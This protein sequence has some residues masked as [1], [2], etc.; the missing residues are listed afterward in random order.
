LSKKN[1]EKRRAEEMRRRNGFQPSALSSSL[2]ERA[3]ANDIDNTNEGISN[4]SEAIYRFS[5]AKS[6]KSVLK[7]RPSRKVVNI[8]LVSIAI[9][10]L[11]LITGLTIIDKTAGSHQQPNTTDTLVHTLLIALPTSGKTLISTSAVSPTNELV[12]KNNEQESLVVTELLSKIKAELAR[13]NSQAAKHLQE[14]LK[15]AKSVSEIRSA[16][17]AY[18]TTL[19]ESNTSKNQLLVFSLFGILFAVLAILC[20]LLSLPGKA[21]LMAL[22]SHQYKVLADFLI[23]KQELLE[24]NIQSIGEIRNI[25]GDIIR[26]T[27]PVKSNVSTQSY[28]GLVQLY[29]KDCVSRGATIYNISSHSRKYLDAI[30]KDVKWATS[31]QSRREN[32]INWVPPQIDSFDNQQTA[33]PHSEPIPD[34]KYQNKFD[35]EKKIEI[36]SEDLRQCRSAINAKDNEYAGLLK[37]FEV[38]RS[39]YILEIGGLNRRNQALK[40]ENANIEENV[41]RLN[42]KISQFEAKERLA[43]AYLQE[44]VRLA[45]TEATEASKRERDELEKKWLETQLALEKIQKKVAEFENAEAARDQLEMAKGLPIELGEFVNGLLE[46]ALHVVQHGN[47]QVDAENLKWLETH[48]KQLD[49]FI[50]QAPAPSSRLMGRYPSFDEPIRLLQI[51]AVQRWVH[52]QIGS[53]GIEVI[54]PVM[55]KPFDQRL[56]EADEQHLVWVTAPEKNNLIDSVVRIG[57]K[58]SNKVLRT[59]IVKKYV[60]LQTSGRTVSAIA[61]D[62]VA[63]SDDMDAITAKEMLP[64]TESTSKEEQET[65]YLSE[66]VVTESSSVLSSVQRENTYDPSFEESDLVHEVEEQF[67]DYGV[68]PDRVQPVNDIAVSPPSEIDTLPVGQQNDRVKE[69]LGEWEEQPLANSVLASEATGDTSVPSEESFGGRAISKEN[70]QISDRAKPIVGETTIPQENKSKRKTSLDDKLSRI[71]NKKTDSE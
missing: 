67:E 25:L 51:N 26:Y 27:S 33:L 53:M 1:A 37:N 6:G 69:E 45:H 5:G 49:Q 38:E 17:V 13:D 23:L 3:L 36:L 43:N 31:E 47:H 11:V 62:V 50:Y 58:I 4:S 61:P 12:I 15:D 22:T 20:V 65:S 66:E 68:L 64:E 29:E 16:L 57:F 71:E 14:Y 32:A 55:G 41:A 44:Q 19:Q 39:K 56:H 40:D 42:D 60:H 24:G 2:Q 8:S 54:D 28:N 9:I 63:T 30:I 10:I 70:E 52:Q 34:F 46:V 21:D 18:N 59:A 7:R 35:L 48:L